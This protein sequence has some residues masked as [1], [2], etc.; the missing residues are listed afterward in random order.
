[1]LT[2]ILTALLFPTPVES[3]T[4]PAGVWAFARPWAGYTV[5]LEADGSYT[6]TRP[7]CPQTGW[8]GTWEYAGGRLTIRERL[9]RLDDDGP[10]LGDWYRY[11][12]PGVTVTRGRLSGGGVEAVRAPE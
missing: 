2:L 4:T 12:W 9:Y 8:F 7:D 11:D 6:A 10:H 1:M 3:P 5:R